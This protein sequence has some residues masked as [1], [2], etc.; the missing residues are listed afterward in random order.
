M[1]VFSH[2]R[3]HEADGGI[4]VVH[5]FRFASDKIVELWDVGMSIPEN[6]VNEK[7]IF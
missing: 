1:A 3:M 4:A 5:I 2:V 7:G 6:V